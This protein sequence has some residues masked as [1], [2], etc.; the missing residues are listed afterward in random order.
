MREAIC[1]PNLAPSSTKFLTIDSQIVYHDKLLVHSCDNVLSLRV[2]MA[3][4][5]DPFPY[6]QLVPSLWDSVVK[7]C[8][9]FYSHT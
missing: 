7:S 4:M 5:H 6:F 8:D 2:T 9:A 3:A 1:N